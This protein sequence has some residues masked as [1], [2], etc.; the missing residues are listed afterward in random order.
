[1]ERGLQLPATGS[2][3]RSRSTDADL[4]DADLDFLREFEAGLIRA[5]SEVRTALALATLLSRVFGAVPEPTGL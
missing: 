1:M 4:P 3:W 2:D 5:G